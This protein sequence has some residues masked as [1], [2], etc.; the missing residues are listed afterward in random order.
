MNAI[1][2]LGRFNRCTRHSPQLPCNA[3]FS[4]SSSKKVFCC[5]DEFDK[6]ICDEPPVDRTED[7][8]VPDSECLCCHGAGQITLFSSTRPCDCSIQQQTVVMV[9]KERVVDIPSFN[10]GAAIP[11][12]RI[13]D[14][15][16]VDNLLACLETK[17]FA[18][19][20]RVLQETGDGLN[21]ENILISIRSVNIF[22]D[23]SPNI[24]DG[25]YGWA[26]VGIAVIA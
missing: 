18:T 3:P 21:L 23:E 11:S 2:D 14:S 15:K 6:I 9:P 16:V 7:I 13:C 5:L 25:C 1:L 12:G 10:V 8:E 4:I 17:I 20:T 26:E 22:D 19:I 24:T